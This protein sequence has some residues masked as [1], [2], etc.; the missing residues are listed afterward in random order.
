MRQR[1]AFILSTIALLVIFLAGA[2]FLLTHRSSET[3]SIMESKGDSGEK[4][5]GG[6]SGAMQAL[7]FWTQARAYPEADISPDKF[8]KAYTYAKGEIRETPASATTSTWRSIGPTNVSGRMTSVAINPRNP[9]TI[10]AGAASGG[11]WRSYSG[12]LSGD[13]QRVPTG[14]PVLGVNAIAI[15]P[16]DT[17]T[18][19]IGTG[20]TY[21]YQGSVGGIVIRTTR[22]SY[23]MGILKTTDGGN[24]WTKSLDWSYNQQRGVQ[25]LHLNPQNPN[26]VFA[27]TSEGVYR[28]NDAGENWNAVLNMLMARDIAIHPDDT[29]KVLA[30]CGNFASPGTGVYRSSDGGSTF[31]SIPGLPGYS[32]FARLEIYAADANVVYVSLAEST[33]VIGSLWRSTDFGL[34]WTLVNNDLSSDVQGWYSRFLAVHPTDSS[35]IVRGAQSLY[36][37]SNGGISFTPI[38]DTWADNHDYAHHPTNPDI[39]YLVD[40]G[41]V[42]RSTNFGDSYQYVGSGLLTLQF[43]NGFSNSATDSLLAL[44][45]VQDNIPGYMYTGDL[46]WSRSAWDEVGWTA[47]DQKDDRFMYAASRNGGAL[48]KSTNRGVSFFSSSSGFSGLSCWNA[49]FVLSRSNTNVLYFGRS[50]IFKTTNAGGSW[51]ATNA[52]NVL[53]GNPALSMAIASTNPDTVFV[54]TAP[55]V[56]RPH[57]F[58]TTNGGTSWTDITGTLPNRYP[59]DMEV[60]PNNSQVVYV[61]F[62]GFDTTH[63]FKS[64]DA[65]ETW[66]DITGTLPDVPATAVA[67]DPLNS[68]HVYVGTDIGVFVSTN[69]GMNWMSFNDGLLEAV[70][71]SDLKVSPSNRALRA[72]THSNGVFERKLVFT[73]PTSIAQLEAGVP[74]QFELSQNYPNPFNPSTK[75]RFLIPNVGTRLAVS[76]QVYDV[77]GRE[78]ATLVNEQLKPGSYETTFDGRD[79]ASG[80]YF[81]RIQ[82]E[83]FVQTKKLILIR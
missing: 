65:G 66:I 5:A 48:Y 9:N 12:E 52:G 14:F 81:Y 24:T 59:M 4:E 8:Y 46:I 58:R 28:S 16:M 19:F 53:D 1:L 44:G 36:K 39:L 33:T 2:H 11:L 73:T 71:V 68:D 60:D 27:A 42:W 56:T 75:I 34:N 41:G 67:V 78:V 83:G 29:T 51:S 7:E 49:P 50:R 80:I 32:G 37:S 63:V 18:V 35:Q 23:G 62:G 22:G 55:R 25:A 30:T 38:F 76:L 26:T 69:G 40:D 6:A 21:R 82:T 3:D 20:E 57:I 54:G 74:E 31:G 10:Y 64:T 70:L 72:A 61:A 47:I 77:T 43:Y 15:N 79:L 45:Q 17:N 13:W